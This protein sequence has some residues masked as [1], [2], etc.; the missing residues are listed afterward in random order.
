MEINLN[1]NLKDLEGNN[2]LAKKDCIVLDDKKQVV[3]KDGV[4]EVV[5]VDTKEA[6]TAKSICLN[7]L[8]GAKTEEISGPDKY[9]RWCLAKK[10]QASSGTTSLEGK[11][12]EVLKGLIG[13]SYNPIVV[14]QLY[15][16]LDN[17]NTE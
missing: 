16:I 6:L 11:E 13:E 17:K 3:L 10:I 12:I 2:L 8:L 5:R 4:P 1:N 7:T 9:D 15:D 14:G